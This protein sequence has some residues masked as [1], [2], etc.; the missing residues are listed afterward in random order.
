MTPGFRE[1]LAAVSIA[2]HGGRHSVQEKL[3]NPN[4]TEK[5]ALMRPQTQLH[6]RLVGR[7]SILTVTSHKEPDWLISDGF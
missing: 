6:H 7:V 2:W 3:L 4:L 5:N 1:A